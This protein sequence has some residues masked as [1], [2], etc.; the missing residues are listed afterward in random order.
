MLPTNITTITITRAAT[1]KRLTTYFVFRRQ[2][3]A[4]R[5]QAAH[6]RKVTVRACPVQWRF[7]L[8]SHNSPTK[9]GV[10]IVNARIQWL[11]YLVS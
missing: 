8:M 6:Q 9:S 2:I 10:H 4:F 3:A 11:K 1:S 7:A 5:H